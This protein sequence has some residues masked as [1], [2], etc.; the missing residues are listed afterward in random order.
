[1][2]FIDQADA[3]LYY[4][5]TGSGYPIVFVHEFAADAREWEHQLRAFS[6]D[7]RCIAFN[8]RGY[9][10]SDVPA[11]AVRYGW[12]S[13]R[14]DLL[15]MLNGLKI[16]KAH[17]VGLSMGAYTALA[18][19]MRH[20]DRVSAIVAAACGSGSPPSLRA[21]FIRDAKN[22]AQAFLELGSAA[23]AEV[24][25]HSPTRIQL[26]R[27]DP[28]AWAEFMSH[29]REHSAE[30]SSHTMARYQAGRPS[31]WSFEAELRRL[32]LPVLVAVGDEDEP[33]VEASLYLK[34]H[35]PNAGLWM[36]PNTGHAINLEE[37]AAFNQVTG[38]FFSAVGRGAWR[39][40]FADG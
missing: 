3:R 2:P 18:F 25:G 34:R 17:L 31:L 23:L 8:A 11:D 9:P 4:E 13:S 40:G 12:E 30:G 7:Y 20:P 1:M 26:K 37:P 10:P 29:L 35:L 6:R 36:A 22:T 28:R 32:R 33:C 5:E 27:K 14:D 38:D 24:I 21:N 39:R 19:G 15:A 16:D